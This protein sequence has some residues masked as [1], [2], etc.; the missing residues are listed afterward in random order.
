[1]TTTRGERLRIARQRHFKSA[2]LAASALDIP[3]S[4]FGAHERAG[5]PGG[6][7]FGVDEAERYGR[8]FGVAAEWLLTGRGSG[9]NLGNPAGEVEPEHENRQ[10]SRAILIKKYESLASSVKKIGAN[11][12]RLRGSKGPFLF[13]PPLLGK[14][15]SIMEVLDCLETV[16]GELE[17]RGAELERVLGSP[18]TTKRS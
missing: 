13:A 7:D 11:L 8:R 16:A 3:V 18:K 4:T 6:R 1:M 15:A 12:I 2:R 9:G 17:K 14:N 5:Q 10:P